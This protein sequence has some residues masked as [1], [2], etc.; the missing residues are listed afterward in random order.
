MK[1]FLLPLLLVAMLI[2]SCKTEQSAPDA[3]Q[4]V[5]A[6]L[7]FQHSGEARALYYQA[8]NLAELRVRQALDTLPDNLPKAVIA[9]IDETI[10][11]NSPSEGKNILES[12]RFSSERWK[13][14]TDKRSAIG[15]PGSLEFARFLETVGVDLYYISNRSVDEQN[16]TLD[17]LKKLGYPFFLLNSFNEHIFDQPFS[18]N[19]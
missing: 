7:W 1:K 16:A 11:D 14:W 18:H 9:D 17:N 19:N 8:Y 2:P 6:T 3:E 4:M 5:M 12:S 13:A 15:L 10:L